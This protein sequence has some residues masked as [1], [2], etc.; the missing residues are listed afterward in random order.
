MKDRKGVKFPEENPVKDIWENNYPLGILQHKIERLDLNKNPSERF[1]AFELFLRLSD[2]YTHLL[3]AKIR[4]VYQPWELVKEMSF[5]SHIEDLF[6]HLRNEE[7]HKGPTGRIDLRN[8]FEI[9]EDKAIKFKLKEEWKGKIEKK[10]FLI[11]SLLGCPTKINEEDQRV[12]FKEDPETYIETCNSII[13]VWEGLRPLWNDIKHGFRLVP[14]DWETIE[15]LKEINF[16]ND[17]SIDLDHK[18][19]IFNKEMEKGNYFFWRL[20]IIENENGAGTTEIT[21]YWIEPKKCKKLAEITLMLINN[22]LDARERKFLVTEDIKELVD[23]PEEDRIET[24]HEFL[25]AE[26]KVEFPK[27]T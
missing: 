7:K 23:Y 16:I 25:S 27:K 13:N 10:Y 18:R 15:H 8:Y 2:I 4:N 22:I 1:E 11:A 14:F 12:K 17:S 20:D 9:P 3:N 21:V 26:I 24:L 6:D 5:I 19:E